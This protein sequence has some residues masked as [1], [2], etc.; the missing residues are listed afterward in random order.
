MS[1]TSTR[2]IRQAPTRQPH[3]VPASSSDTLAAKPTRRSL[4]ILVAAGV[5]FAG[6]L[7]AI[8]SDHRAAAPREGVGLSGSFP[9]TFLR[10]T[11]RVASFNIHAGR[12]AAGEF[13]LARTAQ[14][15]EGFDVVG[16]NEVRGYPEWYRADHAEQLGRLLDMSW[17]FAPS[18]RRYWYD[19]WGNGLLSKLPV[20]EWQSVPLANTR[21]KGYRNYTVAAV[22]FAG[23]TTTVVVT[24]IDNKNDHEHQLRVVREV[25]LQQPAPAILMGDLNGAA[26][27]PLVRSIAD[28]PEVTDALSVALGTDWEPSVDWIFVR[29]LEVRDAGVRDLGASDHK[30]V[31]AELALPS[32]RTAAAQK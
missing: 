11:L 28:H 16:L 25:F 9:V 32:R 20:G 4:I 27:D 29:G 7:L 12:N 15:L 10:R 24:H 13:D 8:G 5:L 6:G 3:V 26:D 14:T 21:G 19:H 23:S 18:E 30:C 17:C 31:W 1:T 22:E 2:T